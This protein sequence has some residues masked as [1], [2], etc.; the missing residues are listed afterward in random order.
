MGF[1]IPEVP[2]T[3]LKARTAVT[4]PNC[5]VRVPPAAMDHIDYEVELAVV[6]S[7]E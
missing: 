7:K 5:V 6:L 2:T 3:F 4:D 1:P